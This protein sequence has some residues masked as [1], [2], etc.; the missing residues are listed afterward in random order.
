MI[1][2]EKRMVREGQDD[3]V[4]I[5]GS[6]A[7]PA[8]D[9]RIDGVSPVTEE[10][11]ASVPAGVPADSGIGGESAPENL[12]LYTEPQAKVAQRKMYWPRAILLI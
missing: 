10:P 9:E 5:G 12:A 4:F 2:E 11:M 3:H 7:Q 1:I 6:W 8:T